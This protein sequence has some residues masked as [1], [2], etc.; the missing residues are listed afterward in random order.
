MGYTPL[1]KLT[2]PSPVVYFLDICITFGHSRVHSSE[3]HAATH[4]VWRGSA[5]GGISG[6]GWYIFLT[7]YLCVC[8]MAPPL[9]EIQLELEI[10]GQC[11]LPAHSHRPGSV[12]STSGSVWAQEEKVRRKQTAEGL[13]SRDRHGN[14]LRKKVHEAQPWICHWRANPSFYTDNQ[15]R[16]INWGE[17]GCY[18]PLQLRDIVIFKR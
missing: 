8:A 10:S 6:D 5:M 15:M 7:A 16:C 9:R 13:E 4:V 11:W 2:S 3:R 17:R 12:S 18:S 1:C 14:G